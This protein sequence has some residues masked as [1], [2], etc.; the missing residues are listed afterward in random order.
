MVFGIKRKKDTTSDTWRED[1]GTSTERKAFKEDN[2]A[3]DKI[4]GTWK[5][6]KNQSDGS[7]S[8]KEE[9]LE[10]DNWAGKD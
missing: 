6:D 5:E 3:Q 4:F 8:F 1:G 2:V 9:K 7:E 10:G